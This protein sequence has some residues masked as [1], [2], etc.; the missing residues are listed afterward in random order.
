MAGIFPGTVIGVISP[1]VIALTGSN[2]NISYNGFLSISRT[3]SSLSPA[4][5]FISMLCTGIAVF[6]FIVAAGG[7]RKTV[8]GDSWDC[9][10][11]SLT[12][13]MQYTATA[14]TKPVRVIFKKI[15]LPKRELSITYIL[16]P[17]FVKS[18]NTAAR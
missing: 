8:Y 6:V 17:L 18:L 16:K 1:S 13:R 12:S 14:F 10:I 9:G 5:I 15:Y 11:H 4:A 3:F 7:K 2:G